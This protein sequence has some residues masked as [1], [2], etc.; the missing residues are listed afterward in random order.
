MSKHYTTREVAEKLGLSQ[1]GIRHR[2]KSGNLPYTA[3]LNKIGYLFEKD[4]IDDLVRSSSSTSS[5]TQSSSKFNKVKNK[6]E[7][8]M[9]EN[10]SKKSRKPKFTN[11][12]KHPNKDKEIISSKSVENKSIVV[13]NNDNLFA[14]S[15]P[16]QDIDNIE[17]NKTDFYTAAE[18][19]KRLKLSIK[20]I[21]KYAREHKLKHITKDSMYLF[22]VNYIEKILKHRGRDNLNRALLLVDYYKLSDVSRILNLDMKTIMQAI[23]D[24]RLEYE[25]SPS[26]R[27]FFKC[28][29]I[30]NLSPSFIRS[31]KTK[32]YYYAGAVKKKFG[33]SNHEFI[34]LV[35]KNKLQ[36]IPD[37]DSK[38]LKFDKKYING[39]SKYSVREWL[40]EIK[41]KKFGSVHSHSAGSASVLSSA[42]LVQPN[43]KRITGMVKIPQVEQANQ[44]SSN[45]SEARIVQ[46]KLNTSTS[47]E[48][49]G[50][51]VA[52]V[53]VDNQHTTEQ[54]VS[55]VELTPQDTLTSHS[56]SD[57]Q[58]AASEVCSTSNGGSLAL[59]CFINKLWHTI[60]F[61]IGG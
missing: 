38:W 6:D 31:L 15:K 29:Y 49:V 5:T 9:S 52:E 60:T 4:Y 41:N 1:R 32:N 8:V 30:D 18:V 59:W 47:V 22:D 17:A 51:G 56:S 43:V 39:L 46:T 44:D 23:K 42:D 20:T 37:D 25:L 40:K 24:N 21:R 53:K 57:S 2:V 61:S 26:N 16:Q 35:S 50:I 36:P 14:E 19:A 13:S 27:Y 33:L 12:P 48:G 54:E 10:N 11:K 7:V 45:S 58:Q 55:N 28:D 3:K 34:T